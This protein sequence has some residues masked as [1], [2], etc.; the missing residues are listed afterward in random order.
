MVADFDTIDIN[1]N[2]GPQHPSTHGVF[3]MVLTV[4]GELVRDLDAVVGY[5]HRGAEKLL[6]NQDYRQGIGIQD[7]TEYLAQ[8]PAEQSYVMAAEKLGGFVV[9]E[10][11]EY[12]RVICVELNRIASHFMFMGAYGTDVGVFGTSFIYGFRE[13]ERV[14]RFFEE[15]TGERM[16][17]SYFRVGGLAWEVMD[18]FE[19]KARALLQE[20]KRGINDI[21]GLLTRNEIFIAR[22]RHVGE[23]SAERAIEYGLSGPVLRSTGVRWD[24]RKDEPYSVYDRFDFD[25]PVGEFGDCYDRYMVRLEEMRQAVRIVEQALDQMPKSGPIMPEKMPRMLRLPAG[26]VYV[27]VESARGEYGVYLVSRGGNHPWRCRVKSP[28]FTNLQALREMTV[29]EYV[30]DSV[31]ILGSID[32]VLS[33]VDR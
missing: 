11:A 24:V 25:V 23:I 6:E 14:Y 13:R 15:L 4:D 31:V 29:G 2:V 10:R 12:V 16:M 17:Y 22:T 19:E 18:G 28:C 1:I 9:P 26:E 33:E 27:P 5:L 30:A 20:L 8:F 7:R 32:L 21:N 3:R